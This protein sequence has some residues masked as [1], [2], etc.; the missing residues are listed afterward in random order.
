MRD[1][2]GDIGDGGEE[3]RQKLGDQGT[4][5]ETQWET[6]WG[7]IEWT[8]SSFGPQHP[9]VMENC[10]TVLEAHS[11]YCNYWEAQE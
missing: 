10:L 7:L 2:V 6:R 11:Q 9:T 8:D 1:K 3:V 5:S 4:K